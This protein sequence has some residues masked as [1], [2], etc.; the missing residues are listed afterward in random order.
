M[1]IEFS[2]EER[3]FLVRKLQRYVD[4]E[5]ELEIGQFQSDFLLDFVAKELGAYFYN[6]GISDAQKVLQTQ[7]ETIADAIYQLEKPTELSR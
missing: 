5:L 6:R 2:K 4:E 3:A 1:N 7:V